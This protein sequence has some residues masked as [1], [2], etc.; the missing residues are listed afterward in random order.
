VELWP[1]TTPV[2]MLGEAYAAGGYVHETRK[3]LD[4][5]SEVAARGGYVSAYVV[6]RIHGTLGRID[7]AFQWLETGYR[8][9]AERKVLLKVDPCLDP[10]RSDPRFHDLLRRMAFTT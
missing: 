10:L 4:Q 5:L 9:R 2:G 8:E 3:T 7:E 6:A 1:G